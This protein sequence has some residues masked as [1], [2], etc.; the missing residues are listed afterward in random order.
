MTPLLDQV[1]RDRIRASLDE[2]ML[3][4][5]AAGTGKTSELVARLV[6]VLAEGRGR[7]D[8]I[9]AVTFTEKAAGE[10]KLRLRAELEKA[11]QSAAPGS[12]R[13]TLLDAAVAR[14]EEAR[15]STIHGFCNDLL[16]ERPVEGKVDPRFQVLTEPEAEALYRRAFDR[17]VEGQLEQPPAGLRRALRRRA[18]MDDG[19]PVE[20]IRRAGWTLTEWRDFRAPW[21]REPFARE[22]SID[23]LVERLHVFADLTKTCANPADGFYADTWL[24]RRISADERVSE[25]LAPRDHDQ[26]EAALVD[27]ARHRQWRRPR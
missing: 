12:R 15:V 5:A 11:R 25:P 18:S 8:S 19:D 6:A 23:R 22:A 20:R 9:V 13:R 26:L 2:S 10:L 3:V 7:A 24:A 4:E 16:H 17:W 1:A 14:L 21:R 27:L